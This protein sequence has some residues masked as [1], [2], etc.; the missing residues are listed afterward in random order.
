MTSFTN[1]NPARLALVTGASG[2]GRAFALGL[3][4]TC[5]ATSPRCAVVGCPMT[6][7]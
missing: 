4:R 7:W 3:T 5:R 2:I 1:H 6:R